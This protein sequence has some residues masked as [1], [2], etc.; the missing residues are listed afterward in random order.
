[1]NED[2]KLL[3]STLSTSPLLFWAVNETE[4]V[5]ERKQTQD[6]SQAKGIKERRAQRSRTHTENGAEQGRGQD[7]KGG[8]LVTNPC[9]KEESPLL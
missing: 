5:W 8:A 6:Q 4:T 2:D 9:P 3:G 7:G 1:M